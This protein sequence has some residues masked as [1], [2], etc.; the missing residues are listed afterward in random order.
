MI[1]EVF[2]NLY[3]VLIEIETNLFVELKADPFMFDNVPIMDTLFYVDK[4]WLM[5]KDKYESGN[6]D[7]GDILSD[8]IN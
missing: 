1:N 5:F 7:A 2:K 6:I 3:E 8:I 4:I